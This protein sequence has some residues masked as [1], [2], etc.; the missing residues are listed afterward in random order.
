MSVP[1]SIFL[2]CV[3]DN[4]MVEIDERYLGDTPAKLSPSY[5]NYHLVVLKTGFI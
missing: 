2:L 4:L 5:T 3:R 1:E